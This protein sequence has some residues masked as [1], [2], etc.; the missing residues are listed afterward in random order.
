MDLSFHVPTSNTQFL[1]DEN[2]TA[3]QVTIGVMWYKNIDMLS[4]T[5]IFLICIGPMGNN[6][7]CCWC[8]FFWRGSCHLWR[9]CYSYTKV[10]HMDHLSHYELKLTLLY[11]KEEPRWFFHDYLLIVFSDN[12]TYFFRNAEDVIVL[13]FICHFCVSKDK[14]MILKSNIAA[15]FAFFFCQRSFYFF[16][17]FNVCCTLMVSICFI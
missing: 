4:T 9:N 3:A 12:L 13:S 15:L 17:L 16:C 2:R 5:E 14:L 10:E 1:G 8:W 7:G 6:N 11:K